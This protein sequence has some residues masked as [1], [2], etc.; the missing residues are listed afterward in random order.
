MLMLRRRKATTDCMSRSRKIVIA[1]EE[2]ATQFVKHNGCNMES[3]T[4]AES[5]FRGSTHMAGVPVPSAEP[6]S[7]V[8]PT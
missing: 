7:H 8:T 6:T 2:A 5:A 4:A 1:K 3:H